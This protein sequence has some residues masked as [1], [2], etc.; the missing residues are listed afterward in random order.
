MS[1]RGSKDGS[2]AT[3]DTPQNAKKNSSQK[4]NKNGEDDVPRALTIIEELMLMIDGD[5]VEE[6]SNSKGAL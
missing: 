2:K 1:K 4:E 3:K 6:G 5:T